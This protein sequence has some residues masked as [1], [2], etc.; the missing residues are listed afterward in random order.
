MHSRRASEYRATQSQAVE[1]GAAEYRA[2]G[3]RAAGYRSHRTGGKITGPDLGSHGN[4][5]AKR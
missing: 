5:A 1:S 4:A 3:Y 2:A